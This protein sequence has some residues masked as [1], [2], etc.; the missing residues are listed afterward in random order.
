MA[1]RGD[2]KQAFYDELV[3][4]LATTHTITYDDGSTE[5]VTLT[6]DDIRLTSPNEDEQLPK[7][8]FADSYVPFD[9]NGVGAA[10]NKI[11]RD[12]TG[13]VDYEEWHQHE[14]GEYTIYINADDEIRKE[15][16]YES[17]Y[18]QFDKYATPLQSESD[19]HEHVT[20]IR[21]GSTSRNDASEVEQPI[22]GD[23]LNVFIDFYRN[24]QLSEDNIEQVNHLI[25]T[26]AFTTE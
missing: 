23:S 12:E 14:T 6:Q 5:Q 9:Y 19:F 13:R 11:A 7:I 18:Q 20:D 3:S 22:R 8:V 2:I 26:N 15:P 10:P 1:K 17:V 24:Y 16:L 4:V 25:E 21:V